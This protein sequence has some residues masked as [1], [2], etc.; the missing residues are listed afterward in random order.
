MSKTS[1]VL[2]GPQESP[3]QICE[4]LCEPYVYTCY[5]P[6]GTKNQHRI[7]AAFVRQAPG[8]SRRKLQKL[9]GFARM[10]ASQ[11]LEVATEV[12][13]TVTRRPKG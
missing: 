12:L 6:E 1:E 9:E 3:S 7:K 8:D 13:R 2:Q 5:D 11:C 10:N 4:Q